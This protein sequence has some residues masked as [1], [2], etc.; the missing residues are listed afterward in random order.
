[1][2]RAARNIDLRQLRY[3]LAVAEELNFRRAAERL[4]VTQPPL[5]RQVAALEEALG[6]RLLARN[7]RSTALTPAGRVAQREFGKLVR[8]FDAALHAIGA[9]APA[10]RERLRIGALWWSDLSRFGAFETALRRASGVP[11]VEPVLGSSLA[12][13]KQLQRGAL[14]ASVV[15]LPQELGSLPSAP[16]ARVQHVAL[17]PARHPLA[18]KR[19]LRLAALVAGPPLLRFRRSENPTLWDHFQRLYDAAGFRP[20]REE[21]AQNAAATLSQIAAGRGWTVMP[22][23]T[24][25][26]CPSGVVARPL[27]DAVYVD[28]VLVAAPRLEPALQAALFKCAGRLRA[29][30]APQ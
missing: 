29:V 10:A 28:A 9:V 18:R 5:S 6:C 1:M 17:I 19:A 12:L 21:P 22:A 8:Q 24:A 26:Q 27:R 16:I 13:L 30:V 20:A 7:T 3:F 25:R 11:L 15:V 23:A 14:D 2:N 4:H